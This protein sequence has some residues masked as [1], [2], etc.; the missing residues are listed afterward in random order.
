M[1]HIGTCYVNVCVSVVQIIHKPTGQ[2]Q[3]LFT[4]KYVPTGFTYCL[5]RK[6]NLLLLSIRKGH[7]VF[8][9]PSRYQTIHAEAQH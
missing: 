9:V 6:E 7:N 1:I 2:F 8:S 4:E 3:V 5:S